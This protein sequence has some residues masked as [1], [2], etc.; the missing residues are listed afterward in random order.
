MLDFNGSMLVARL[1]GL[2]LLQAVVAPALSSDSVTSMGIVA[3]LVISLETFIVRHS[4]SEVELEPGVM[5]CSV[6]LLVRGP[7][8]I[9]GEYDVGVPGL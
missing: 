3:S 7:E 9:V 1:L 5:L 8:D 2:G 6:G 4:I